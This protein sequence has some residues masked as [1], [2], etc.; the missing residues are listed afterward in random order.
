M[1]TSISVLPAVPS[2]NSAPDT[3]ADDADLFLGALPTFRTEA[4]ALGAEVEANKNTAVTSANNA[5]ISETNA[6][7]SAT[8]AA[9]SA[10]SAVNA[11]GTSGTS[12]TSLTV[13]TGSK[14]FTTQ[15]GKAWVV[16]QF[17]TIAYTTTPTTYMM[18]QITAYTSGSGAMTVN[19]TSTGGSGTQ[20]AWTIG[21]TAPS[22]VGGGGLATTTVTDGTN[23]VEINAG[24]SIEI[25][26]AAGTGSIDFKT[27]TG[28]DYD[29]RIEQRSNGIAVKTGGD[30]ATAD[31]LVMDSSQRVG[32]GKTPGAKLDYRET[33]N[34]Q[35]TNTTAVASNTYILTASITLTLPASPSAGD[36]VRIVNRSGT[37]TCVVG[38]NSTNIM[39]LA[40][41]MTITNLNLGF[42][43]VYTDA[44]RGWV[45]EA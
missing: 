20:T 43:L 9:A 25:Q 19:V 22:F 26:R 11:P 39:G 16:G 42:Y 30:G 1:A 36:W 45:M 7:I 44:T 6:G 8:N 27:G 5:A 37:L 32:I 40:E 21:L 35:G 10:L 28:E 14:S 13:G 29:A 2:R 24:G 41:D 23:S 34:I 3:F 18:G 17:V 31:A 12:T 4:N 38:R 33:I 15:T